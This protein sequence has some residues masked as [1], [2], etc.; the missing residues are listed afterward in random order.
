MTDA[1]N[2][3]AI[4]KFLT[5]PWDDNLLRATIEE[6]FRNKE[7]ADEKTARKARRPIDEEVLRWKKPPKIRGFFLRRQ[8]QAGK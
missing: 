7:K 2:V 5:K 1:I 4:Y 3:G 8:Y 6:A